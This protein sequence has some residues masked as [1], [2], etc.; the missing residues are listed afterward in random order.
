MTSRAG[1]SS[2]KS[3]RSRKYESVRMMSV[4]HAICR[5]SAYLDDNDRTAAHLTGLAFFVDFT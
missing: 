5:V 4:E 1:V 3:C 2:P